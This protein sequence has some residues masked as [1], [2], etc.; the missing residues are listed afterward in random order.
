MR[1][2]DWAGT[3]SSGQRQDFGQLPEVGETAFITGVQKV[4]FEAAL[5]GEAGERGV[6]AVLPPGF[7]GG[8]GQGDPLGQAVF[9]AVQF[10][11]VLCGVA[12]ENAAEHEAQVFGLLRCQ[13]EQQQG[14]QGFG[15]GRVEHRLLLQQYAAHAP[16]F[17]RSS[18]QG[19]FAMGANQYG[20]LS[21]MQRHIFAAVFAADGK[22]T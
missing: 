22:A 16:A 19:G 5:T 13:P 14:V 6:D 8:F 3:F 4:L 11:Q 1:Q 2:C 21:R 10:G 18:D 20:H 12:I 9:V 17:E 15:F 7:G